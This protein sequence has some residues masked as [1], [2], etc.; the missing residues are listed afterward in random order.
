MKRLWSILGIAMLFSGL[1]GAIAGPAAWAGS[2]TGTV[3][4][5]TLESVARAS[6]GDTIEVSGSGSF[7]LQPKSASGDA[8]AIEAAFGKVPRTFT[9]RDAD[10][11]VL[12]EGT[13]EPTQ[14]LSYRSFGSATAEQNAELG[15]PPRSEGGKMLIKVALNVDGVHVHDG[16]LTI[17]CEL[18]QPPKNSVEETLLLVQETQFNFNEPV[19]GDN[20]F[21]RE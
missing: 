2:K 6:N 17:V 10:G 4:F 5:G 12:A 1:I 14:V 21:I 7:S 13:W 11:N 15:L 19:S 8:P 16:I 9:H 20:I 3:E 18:G